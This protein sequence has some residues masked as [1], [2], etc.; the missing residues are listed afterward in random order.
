MQK[1]KK[2][3]LVPRFQ[4]ACIC[5]TCPLL[6]SRLTRKER[7]PCEIRVI[8]PEENQ[9]PQSGATQPISLRTAGVGAGV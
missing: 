8:P 5:A 4:P 7:F 2:V 1:E 9:P 3:E 6:L